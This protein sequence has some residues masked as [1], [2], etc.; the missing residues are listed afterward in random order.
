MGGRLC[1][2]VHRELDEMGELGE[3]GDLTSCVVCNYL[4]LIAQRSATVM[5]ALP[6]RANHVQTTRLREEGTEKD[7]TMALQSVRRSLALGIREW[8]CMASVRC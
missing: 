3:L 4:C 5:R 2:G 7:S 6:R 1:C 8:R